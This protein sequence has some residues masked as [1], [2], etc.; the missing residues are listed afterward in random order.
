MNA[1]GHQGAKLFPMLFEILGKKDNK[2]TL[3]KC[4]FLV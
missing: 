2:V 1:T 4:V 3:L